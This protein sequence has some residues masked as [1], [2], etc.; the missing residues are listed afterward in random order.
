MRRGVDNGITK[1]ELRGLIVQVT[2]YAGWPSGLMAGRAA[3]ELLEAN[4]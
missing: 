4:E 3:L 2:F 1:D